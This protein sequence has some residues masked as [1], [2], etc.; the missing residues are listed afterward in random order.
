MTDAKIAAMTAATDARTA[1]M[2]A[3]TAARTV[4]TADP[5]PGC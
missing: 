3:A 4:A 1:A 2:I 5:D